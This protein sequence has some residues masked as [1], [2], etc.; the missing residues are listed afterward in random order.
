M[1]LSPTAPCSPLAPLIFSQLA[2]IG[3]YEI[4]V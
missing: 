4:S 1:I 2:E 3:I